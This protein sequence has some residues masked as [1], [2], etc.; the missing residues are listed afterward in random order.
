[1]GMTF[2][3]TR[4]D[5]CLFWFMGSLCFFVPLKYFGISCLQLPFA[6]NFFILCCTVVVHDLISSAN[7]FMVSPPHRF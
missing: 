5:V 4:N 6:V 7:V 1:M 2:L 3:G